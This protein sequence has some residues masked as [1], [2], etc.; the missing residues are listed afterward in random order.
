M[1][2]FLFA[3]LITAL[4]LVSCHASAESAEYDEWPKL[5]Q[6][7]QDAGRETGN[8][9]ASEVYPMDT[10][11]TAVFLVQAGDTAQL[12][13]LEAE[14]NGAWQITGQNDTIP[15]STI[16]DAELLITSQTDP[17]GDWIKLELDKYIPSYIF[18]VP[19]TAISYFSLDFQRSQ[20]GEWVLC[21]VCDVPFDQAREGRCP[22]HLLYCSD[23]IWEYRFYE[24]IMNDADGVDPRKNVLLIDPT[25]DAKEF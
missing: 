7:L 8:I 19:R 22:Y 18:G 11:E 24:E 10:P 6:V 2:R 4:L 13:V 17:G 15:V 9:L 25:I 1:K 5:I 20:T 14:K 16:T 23:G 21:M 3:I 12:T